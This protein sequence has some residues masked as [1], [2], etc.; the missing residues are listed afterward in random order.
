MLLRL[1]QSGGDMQLII[2]TVF[3]YAVIILLAS[4][5]HECAH[6]WTAKLL[7]DDTAYRQ[8]RISL[9]PMAHLDPIGTM[10]ILIVGM[11][12][13]K[14]VPVNPV[15]ARKVSARTAMALTA[16]A[17]PISNVLVSLVFVVITR[18]VSLTAGADNIQTVF[19]ICYALIMVAEINIG[20]AIFNLIPVPPLDG[21]RVLYVFLKEKYYFAVMKYEQFIMYGIL[22]LVF[23]GVLDIPL[24]FLNDGIMWLIDLAT[25]VIPG[26]PLILIPLGLS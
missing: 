22:L 6:A 7:G 2:V 20:L 12:W 18:L 11:G 13:A 23:I 25:G 16:A 9:N 14:P 17:G 10:G 15:R 26:N 19:Y 5:I 1:M 4:P 24:R 3:A 21:S 8:G